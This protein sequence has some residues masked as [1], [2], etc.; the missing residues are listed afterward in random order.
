MMMQ[1]CVVAT[2]VSHLADLAEVHWLP[3]HLGTLGHF[4]SDRF[5]QICRITV[6]T[7]HNCTKHP[8]KP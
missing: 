3:T 4:F 5:E 7:V 2:L 8:G 1:G 6:L